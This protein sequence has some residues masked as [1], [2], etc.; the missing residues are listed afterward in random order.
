MNE[1]SEKTEY[2]LISVI[3]PV[4]NTEKYLKQCLESLQK[5]TMKNIEV[6][7]IDDGSDDK[8]AS[9]C[10]SFADVDTRFQVLHK[11]NEGLSAARNDGLRIS[12]AKYI[13]SVDSDDWVERDFCEAA[14]NVAEENKADIVAFRFAKHGKK[15]RIIKQKHFPMEGIITREEALTQYW[16]SV[17]VVV[18]N[19][20]YRRD[21]FEG[22]EYPKG[23]LCEDDA[24]THR[25]VYNAK[26][27]YLLDRILIHHR[28]NRPGS[29]T[30]HKSPEC[31]A[32]AAQFSFRRIMDLKEWG[33]KYKKEDEEILALSYLARIG[34]YAKYSK[35]CDR[36]LQE[37]KVFTRN[38]TWAQRIMFN[39]YKIYEFPLNLYQ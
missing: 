16:S 27:I 4:Y 10:D 35:Q 1:P 30:N 7:I 32:D 5:Q 34:R 25:V 20:L 23:Y 13:M 36:I 18:W 17:S 12:Q 21:L 14:Y 39:I 28:Y 9:I 3:V 11:V 22:I 8:S 19:K 33:Y 26:T 31:K 2:P 38:T 37:C 29:I 24:V 6:L 15:D